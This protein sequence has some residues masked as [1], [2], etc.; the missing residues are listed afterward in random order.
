MYILL[1]ICNF[2]GG[3]KE[4]EQI[5]FWLLNQWSPETTLVFLT[6]HQSTD[7]AA[8]DIWISD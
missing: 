1:A 4:C 8:P 3:V 6:F 7:L 2:P 5:P